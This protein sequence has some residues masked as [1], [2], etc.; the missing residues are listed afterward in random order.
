MANSTEVCPALPAAG[1]FNQKI[2]LSNKILSKLYLTWVNFTYRL[3]EGE[4][5]H[6]NSAAGFCVA[7]LI[8]ILSTV[9]SYVIEMAVLPLMRFTPSNP[10][11]L[12]FE[13]VTTF[14]EK[15]AL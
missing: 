1:R 11:V 3:N 15:H 6:E 8:Y 5:M 2:P 14:R 13:T 4:G 10:Q 9:A 7:I 12:I